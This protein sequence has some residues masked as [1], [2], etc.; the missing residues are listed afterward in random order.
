MIVV[1]A[2]TWFVYVLN[3]ETESISNVS[4]GESFRPLP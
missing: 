3:R 2:I 4:D 1:S